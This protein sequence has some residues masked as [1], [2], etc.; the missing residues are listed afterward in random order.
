MITLVIITILSGF[1]IPAYKNYLIRTRVAEAIH[2]AR[3][4]QLQVAENSYMGA[5]FNSGERTFQ[6]TKWIRSMV[7]DPTYGSI[8]ITFNKHPLADQSL[9]LFPKD[10]LNDGTLTDL[11]GYVNASQIPIGTIQWGC[12]SA[13][14]PPSWTRGTLMAQ[15]APEECRAGTMYNSSQ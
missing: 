10:K 5:A 7:V 12:R 8:T 1:A 11:Q 13:G 4:Y 3:T 9:L 2:L 15:Y 6:P 14:T